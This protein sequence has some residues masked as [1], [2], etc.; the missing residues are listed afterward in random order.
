MSAKV[1]PGRS[2][3]STKA[4]SGPF[5]QPQ[6]EIAGGTGE[7]R[8]S[9]Q[10][11][12]AIDPC[13]DTGPGRQTAAQLPSRVSAF[14]VAGE[15]RRE[16]VTPEVG[17]GKCRSSTNVRSSEGGG[18]MSPNG[19][20]SQSFSTSDPS[21]DPRSHARPR[22]AC[23]GGSRN[24]SATFRIQAV[25]QAG[26]KQNPARTIGQHALV[27]VPHP[28]AGAC[29]LPGAAPPAGRQGAKQCAS[30][31]GSFQLSPSHRHGIAIAQPVGAHERLLSSRR[32]SDGRGSALVLGS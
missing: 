32:P 23:W 22:R 18:R 28:G 9:T 17:K 8:A 10:K 19:R 16:R 13:I 6:V 20:C 27:P 4:I 2:R 26:R 7:G 11:G 21:D 15:W 5:V 3:C 14:S 29:R 1:S 31:S 30:T 12:G 25:N 24:C